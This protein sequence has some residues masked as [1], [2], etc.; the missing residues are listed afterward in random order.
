MRIMVGGMVETRL[1]MSAAA[2]LAVCFR[3]VMG[4]LDTAWLLKRAPLAGGYAAS[5][6]RYV[7]GRGHGHGVDVAP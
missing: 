7:V 3:D 2:A 5:G 1:G 6:E 4:D